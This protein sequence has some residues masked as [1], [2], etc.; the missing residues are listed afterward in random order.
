MDTDLDV[1]LPEEDS[2]S[3]TARDGKKYKIDLFIPFA[4]GAFILENA[5]ALIE[6]FPGKGKLPKLSQKTYNLFLK[7]FALVCKEQHEQM[8]EEWIRHN[9]SLP[10]TIAIIV[11]MIKPIFSYINS[12][13]IL[14]TVQ[15]VKEPERE[16]KK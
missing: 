14:E 16:N 11:Q 12:L 13:G 6:V 3:F 5:E 2:V 4:V 10:R 1:L 15:P 7:I 8:T 9:I